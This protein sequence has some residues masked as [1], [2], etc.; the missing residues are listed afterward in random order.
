MSIDTTFVESLLVPV[1]GENPSGP[2]LRHDRRYDAIREARPPAN[3]ALAQEKKVVDW[4]KVAE[5]TSQLL[6]DTKDLELGG[7]LA[8]ALLRR[9]A[10]PG[11]ANGL[12]VMQGMLDRFWDTVHPEATEEDE[13]EE[14]V[15]VGAVEW[16]NNKLIASLEDVP[17]A[18]EGVTWG[19]YSQARRIPTEQDAERSEDKAEA[20]RDAISQGRKPPEDVDGSIA[21][22]S[23]GFYG[24]L[25]AGAKDAGDAM[26][27][28]D[29]TAGE[30]FR[31]SGV[32]LNGLRTAIE[33]LLKLAE[34]QFVAK[35]GSLQAPVAAGAENGAGGDGSNGAGGSGANSFGW[36][37][38][39]EDPLSGNVAALAKALR[40]EDRGNPA[41][42]LMLRG[43]RW[44]ELRKGVESIES[45]LEAPRT[46]ERAQIKRLA[47]AN[48]WPELIE[49][50]ESLMAT[51]RGRAWLDAQRYVLA[52]CDAM[53]GDFETVAT[54]IRSELRSLLGALPSL[55]EM[56]MMDDT[57]T[58]NEET[59]S[60]LARE[61]L[62]SRR[63]SSAQSPLTTDDSVLADGSAALEG[64]LVEEDES[65][66]IAGGDRRV[67]RRRR[68][69]F[70]A[71]AKSEIAA[72]RPNR[73]IELLVE[74]LDQ[75]RSPRGR[76]IRQTQIAHVMVEAELYSV[77]RP[78]LERLIETIDERKLD[79]WESGSLIAHPMALLCRVIDRLSDGNSNEKRDELYLRI[80]R[81]D[82]LQAMAL[83]TPLSTMSE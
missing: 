22:T 53:G 49:S 32:N 11:L 3:N 20:R 23:V 59:R 27:A 47:M 10:M 67:S 65:S 7:F 9:D 55:P 12:T 66:A 35:G 69:D 15:R 33:G 58:A 52:A 62:F 46:D 76:F 72:K 83:Q 54:A 39:G 68:T 45:L 2:S 41:P 70:F 82:P 71:S 25:Y 18:N 80:C 78:I 75:E 29:R 17:I 51:P 36:A 57:P 56:M 48:Q 5:L 42:Y 60:W 79:E 30:R 61:G 13:D 81:L 24:T 50:A 6:V 28:L 26:I 43:L 31:Y 77:A 74:Q 34:T 19:V 4:K 40:Q 16:L 21:K 14:E 64:A 1:S 8:E 37:A 73:A 38:N 63:N 44:G